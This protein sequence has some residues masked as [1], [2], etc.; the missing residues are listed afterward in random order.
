MGGINWLALAI[1]AIGL[2]EGPRGHPPDDEQLKAATS[3]E[4]QQGGTSPPHSA[5][6]TQGG[7]GR[8]C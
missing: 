2:Q 5:W 1:A 7:R 6:L 8:E 4:E 3:E